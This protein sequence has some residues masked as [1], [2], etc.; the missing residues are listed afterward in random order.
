MEVVFQ[1][2]LTV[3]V[4]RGFEQMVAMGAFCNTIML[5]LATTCLYI[6]IIHLY[7]SEVL[8]GYYI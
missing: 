3:Y 8:R 2:A 1:A 6:S 7:Q 4:S 5:H